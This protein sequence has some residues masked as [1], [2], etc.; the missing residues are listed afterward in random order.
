MYLP[1]LSAV[2]D[3][4]CLDSAASRSLELSTL[5]MCNPPVA[6]RGVDHTAFTQLPRP[7]RSSVTSPC[8]SKPSPV[9]P[10]LVLPG[11]FPSRCGA[12][13]EQLKRRHGVCCIREQDTVLLCFVSL[14][15]ITHS[16]AVRTLFASLALAPGP[17]LAIERDDSSVCC[18]RVLAWIG[19]LCRHEGI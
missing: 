10:G 9:T 5:I 6:A 2:G 14:C 3:L 16:N 1:F 17:C 13:L 11:A 7:R 15:S 4:W 18:R 8:A 19:R 12:V